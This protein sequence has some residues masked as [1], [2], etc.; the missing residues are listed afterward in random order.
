MVDDHRF[1]DLRVS[2]Q[3]VAEF[4]DTAAVALG[5]QRAIQH[6]MDQRGL[7][8]AADSGHDCEHS[9]RNHEVHVLQIVQRRAK[10]PQEFAVGLVANVRNR[11][12]QFSAKI[13]ASKRLV[14]AKHGFIG[15]GE[16]QF[17]AEFAS[18][19]TEIDHMVRGKNRLWIVLHNQNSIAEIAQRFQNIYQPLRI[20]RMQADGRFVEHVQRADQMRAQRRSKLNTLRLPTRQRGSKPIQRKIIQPNLI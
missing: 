15:A 11:N 17:A 19:R 16:E 18:A 5:P 2:F 3:S 1:G 7:P 20:P 10:Q 9:K 13:T 8:G 12:A 6:I 4:F 14:L